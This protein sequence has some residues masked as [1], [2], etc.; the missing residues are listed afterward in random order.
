MAVDWERTLR[1]GIAAYNRGEYEQVLANASEDVE[2]RRADNSPDS[3]EVLRGREQVLAWFHPD[4]FE[5][6]RIELLEFELG[7]DALFTRVRFT[8]RGSGSG[9]PVE[10]ESYT[11]YRISGDQFTRLEIY[12]DAD[13]ARA[14]AGL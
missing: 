13:E 10:I 5:D 12:V 11:V 6:Q 4:V 3:R 8:A 14:A 2:L 7:D 1:D 9:L